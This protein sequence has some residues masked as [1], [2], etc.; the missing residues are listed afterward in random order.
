MQMDLFRLFFQFLIR[1]LLTTLSDKACPHR[2]VRYRV[3]DK[4]DAKLRVQIPFLTH[5]IIEM[6]RHEKLPRM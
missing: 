3:G 5:E 6:S 4:A 1:V 2:T